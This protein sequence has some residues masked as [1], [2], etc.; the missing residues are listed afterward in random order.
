MGMLDILRGVKR[1]DEDTPAI[2]RAA[3]ETR[4][5]GL[6]HDQVPFSI[7]SGETA[8]L[9]AEWKIVDANWYVIFGKAG[10]EKSHR[11]YLRLDEEEREVRALEESWDVEWRAGA[12]N[13]SISVEKFQGRTFGSKSFGTGY[14][15]TGINPLKFGEAYNYRFDVSEM[16]DPIIETI[17]N[18][19]WTYVPV[20]TKGKV[21]K[22]A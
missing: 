6:N 9:E 19:G 22:V 16:K 17:T 2:S 11:I 4:L 15:F 8:D 10:I 13:L 12:P 18:A 7:Q 5:L 3:L 21:K 1:P 14:A 20:A